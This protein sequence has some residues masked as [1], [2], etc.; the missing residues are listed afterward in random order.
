MAMAMAM[1]CVFQFTSY[2]H[3]GARLDLNPLE[4]NI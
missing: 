2:P 4:G 1:A 3:A